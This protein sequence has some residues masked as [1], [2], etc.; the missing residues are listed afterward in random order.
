MNLSDLAEDIRYADGL[1]RW[2]NRAELHETIQVWT[3]E[4][5]TRA[6]VE[7]LQA[8]GIPASHVFD[9]R[10]LFSN[11]HL[12]QRGYYQEVRHPERTGLG[13]R[14]YPRSPF[15]VRHTEPIPSASPPGI[16][17][18]NSEILGDLLGYGIGSLQ[19]F[20]DSGIAGDA[21]AGVQTPFETV[22]LDTLLEL[23]QIA[24]VDANY[25]EKLR[26]VYP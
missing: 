13:R 21:P 11:P 3:K 2:R 1:A 20:H 19:M 6:V 14:L 4:R 18:H 22:S 23:G 8:A 26:E 16:G 10:D 9:N 12:A 25:Q 24:S 17:E 5:E 15:L 7:A